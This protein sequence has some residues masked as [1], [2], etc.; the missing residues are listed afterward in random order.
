[1]LSSSFSLLLL[2]EH[3]HVSVSGSAAGAG[4]GPGAAAHQGVL[5]EFGRAEG[6]PQ[7]RQ[8]G[9]GAAHGHEQIKVGH[10]KARKRAPCPEETSA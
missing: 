7:R 9:D 4:R 8:Q 3:E 5:P 6:R 1:M 2:Q 10:R